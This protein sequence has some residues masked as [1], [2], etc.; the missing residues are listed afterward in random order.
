MYPKVTQKSYGN[1]KRFMSP[2][3]L[4]LMYG[5]FCDGIQ[6]GCKLTL[7]QPNGMSFGNIGIFSAQEPD[8]IR[9]NTMHSEAAGVDAWIDS[10]TVNFQN[11]TNESAIMGVTASFKKLYVGDLKGQK[12]FKLGIHVNF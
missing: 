2:E 9:S 6:L 5:K 3:P 10:R 4:L 12:Q 8:F 11:D 7:S 1:E